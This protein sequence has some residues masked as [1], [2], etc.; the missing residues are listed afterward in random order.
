MG[1]EQ[2]SFVFLFL[3]ISG[4]PIFTYILAAAPGRYS[5]YPVARLIGFSRYQY[6]QNA[7][8]WGGRASS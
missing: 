5:S 3:I 4:S 1:G 2:I 6:Y 7:P 8:G